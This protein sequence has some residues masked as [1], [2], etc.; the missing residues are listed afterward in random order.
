MRTDIGGRDTTTKVPG[1]QQRAS[2]SG[3]V[4]FNVPSQTVQIL[5]IV[6][7]PLQTLGSHWWRAGGLTSTLTHYWRLA[8]GVAG[9]GLARQTLKHC[10]NIT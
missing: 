4:R 1:R 3:V 6:W 9:P 7:R 10:K 8:D 2:L 5:T